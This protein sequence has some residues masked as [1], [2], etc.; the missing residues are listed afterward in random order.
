MLALTFQTIVAFTMHQYIYYVSF[1][2]ARAYQAA[3]PNP[4]DQRRR[5]FQT[6]KAFIPSKGLASAALAGAREIPIPNSPE[7]GIIFSNFGKVGNI[8]AVFIPVPKPGEDHGPGAVIDSTGG[9]GGQSDNWIGVKIR[10]P[11]VAIPLGAA[12]RQE[13]GYLT[14]AAYS[15]LGR[16][17]TQSECRTF[18]DNFSSAGV[19]AQ[20]MEDQGC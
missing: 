4:A 1:M 10:V 2:A 11:F 16:E 9:G 19:I 8:E 6:I 17:V 18:F 15:Y 5:A 13:F 3:G 12:M 7:A 14:L 20:E